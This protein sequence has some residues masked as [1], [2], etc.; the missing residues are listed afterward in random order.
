VLGC[1]D[2]DIAYNIPVDLMRSH[3]DALNIT[4]RKDGSYYYHIKI[5]ELNP[6]DYQLQLPKEDFN[7]PLSKHIVELT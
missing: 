7:L 1:A 3:L 6:G 4:E 5:V 2:L